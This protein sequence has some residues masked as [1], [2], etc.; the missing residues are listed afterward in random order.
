[1]DEAIINKNEK[2][3][4]IK[5]EVDEEVP[6]VPTKQIIKD[7][8]KKTESKKAAEDTIEDKPH[9][10]KNEEISPKSQTKR[11]NPKQS[12]PAAKVGIKIL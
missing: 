6:V 8:E 11:K 3:S 10:S 5:M 9:V 12:Q 4:C 2:K 7:T 1:M